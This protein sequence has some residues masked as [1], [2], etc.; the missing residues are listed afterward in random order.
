MQPCAIF[1]GNL[2]D[3]SSEA[4]TFAIF[5]ENLSSIRPSSLMQLQ[6]MQGPKDVFV[7]FGIGPFY[8]S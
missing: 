8:M 7:A 5:E 3:G 2:G 6:I 4:I 1:R